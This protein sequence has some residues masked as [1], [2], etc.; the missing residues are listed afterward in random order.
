M[1]LKHTF[2]LLLFVLITTVIC[3]QETYRDNFTISNYGN[4]NG[5]QNFST[6][7]IEANDGGSPNNGNI[8]INTPFL[9][10]G[11]L[12]F[13]DIDI[14]DESIRRSSD[15]TGATSATLS[16]N[17][18]TVDLDGSGGN[19]EFLNVQVSNN[20]VNYTTI[21][22]FGGDQ[23][24]TFSQNISGF[25]SANTTVR[26]INLSNW[27]FGDW[28]GG[29][30]VYI[31]NFQISAVYPAL[32]LIDDVTVDEGAGTATFTATMSGVNA[33]GPFTVN[34]Q[35]ANGSATAGSDFTTT[36]GTL[37]FN[38]FVGQ[39]RTIT[40]PILD[41][42]SIEGNETFTIQMT[43][44]SNPSVVI[45]DIGTGTII[46]N[47][48]VIM[49]DGGTST[50]CGLVFF[51]SGGLGNYGNNR[52]ETFT[53]CPDGANDYVAVDF[54][55]FDVQPGDDL[56][57][58]QGTGTGGTLIGQYDNDNIPTLITSADGSGCLTFRF[59]SNGFNSGAGWEAD[60]ICYQD[61]PI[62]VIDDITFDEDV[63][64]AVFTVTH[65]GDPHT[66]F[67]G[68]PVSFTVNY[69]T[70][71]GTAL[72][73]SD[74]TFTSGTLTFNGQ[75]GQSRTISVPIAD[76]G[77]PEF[78]E[79]FTIE[80]T[81]ANFS[82][83]P[84]NFS[85]TAD[86]YI[87]S[88]ILANVPLTLFKQ[89]DGD[90]DYVTTGG[91]LRT[92]A[93][94]NNG[95]ACTIQ[96]SS[97]NQL[98]SN[99]PATGTIRAAY[100][101]WAHSSYVRDE[102]VTF[103]GQTVN[104]SSVYQTTVNTGS[105]EVSFYGYVSDV[106]TLVSGITDI[107]SNTFDFTDL[108]IDNSFNYCQS[109][110][111]L[112]GWSLMVFY[113]D[114]G[115]PAVN[116]NLYQGFDGLRYDSTSFTL[117]SFF[118]IAGVGAKA[119][120]LTWEGDPDLGS[121]G[122]TP[123]RL[124]ITNQSG[125]TSTLS[126]DGGQTG[127]N[128]Y[129]STIFDNTATPSAY[130]TSNIYGLDLDTYDI[131]S[132]ITPGD[133][134]VTANVNVGQDYVINNAVV[135]K[136]P[137]N[138]ITGTVFE[139]VNYP[140]GNGRNQ[141]NSGGVPVAGAIV[142]LFEANGTFIE[143]KNTKVNGDYTFAGMEDGNYLVK[144]VN[145]S[146]RSIRGGGLNCTT[147]F[148]VQTYRSFGDASSLT[149]VTTE[150]GGANP[151]ATQDAALGI[152]NNA[153]SVSAVTVASNGVTGI[154][155]GFNFNTIVNTNISGQ[156]SLEQFVINSNNLDE[157][158]LDVEANGL[159]DPAAGE[160]ISIFMIPPSS[161]SFGRTADANF[162]AGYFDIEFTNGSPMSSITDDN[163]VIDGLTQTSYSG[164]TNTGALGAGGSTVGVSNITLPTYDR[165]EIQ[166]HRNGGDVIKTSGNNVAIRNLSVFSRNNAAIRADG[167]SLNIVGNI[168]G[169]DAVGNSDGNILNGISNLGADVLIDSNYISTVLDYAILLDAGTSN[170]I[171]NNH[172]TNSGNFACD[173]AIL[174]S[175]NASGV[176]IEQ[177]LIE[178]S[179]STAIDGEINN[180]NVIITENSLTTSGQNGG[181][182]S[183]AAQQMAIKLAGNGSEITNNKIYS[184]GGA[185]I[186][187]IGG[188]SNL[189]SQN[190]IYANGTDGDALGI[191]LNDDGVTLNDLGD[192][193]S[194][195][196][197]LLNFPLITGAYIAGPNLV[198]EGQ[199]RPGATI[200]WF[201][202]DITEGTASAGD[203]QLGSI[204]DYGEGQT[205]IGFFTEGS[206][207]DLDTRVTPYT[208]TDGNTDNTNKFKFSM[209]LP[210]GITLTNLVTA[211]ATSSNS[212]SEFSPV[213]EVKAYTV[214]INRR[215]TYRIRTN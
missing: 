105:A 69:Q 16:F 170:I 148:P 190:S 146:V 91:S 32:I 178:N 4:N 116:I 52:D 8:Q 129:N 214:I 86:G 210:P 194:G 7:W 73:G 84:V 192:G 81:G 126:G 71:D 202:T 68:I 3:S 167:G 121:G 137:S 57:V 103:E 201:V 87:S 67:L 44:T 93:N 158:G 172:V 212:T 96:A 43:A 83:E 110:T 203:N 64:N 53:I 123:E 171:R 80:L 206:G 25:I 152:L 156:G 197:G 39:S 29:E 97:S 139:D 27:Q 49:T 187:I 162:S 82:N 142:E 193:D 58:Y 65:T 157:T 30:F 99:I 22:T 15:L 104:A 188:T 115:L 38:G 208:D 37:N 55:S 174:L 24:G 76:D 114:P 6:D 48:A 164:N 106:T 18:E 131:S 21:G 36:T 209:P 11:R 213:S 72:A 79:F 169:V 34:Y 185:G 12:R 141:V 150:I 181:N 108:T 98:T 200:E 89:F 175:A 198:F 138:L 85:D 13:E 42:G 59:I 183:G 51:D 186:A 2:T 154:D 173:D 140:G 118:A 75:V 191:D 1:R 50:Q 155:F 134:Q 94:G 184:N 215:I 135:I 63:G 161:D 180:G 182:C 5:S 74:Y 125:T 199:S 47:D 23:T 19:A 204:N 54:T 159:F 205:F 160:D 189:I 66:G 40:V 122:A 117:D 45:T 177:N 90:F 62:M 112:G 20:G 95:V 101:Y 211:T 196:N 132:F 78:M 127:N 92:Q 179:A 195:P 70:V 33:G 120:F 151:S 207:A 31:D 119:T 41:D 28:E 60:I 128:A 153:Q 113:E 133:S 109:S 111:V 163:T 88:Q 46:D 102:Q 107:N 149:D 61:G 100:L 168:I 165:P 35:T 144:V 26:F 176:Q 145:S 166:V 14:N 10:N 136:V 143:R 17:W 77:I 56:F 124:S 9:G 147:C 130:N